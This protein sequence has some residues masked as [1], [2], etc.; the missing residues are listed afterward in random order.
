MGNVATVGVTQNTCGCHIG[1]YGSF[2]TQVLQPNI[3]ATS[4]T[5]YQTGTVITC[6]GTS[7]VQTKIANYSRACNATEHTH[8]DGTG[9]EHYCIADGMSLSVEGSLVRI[10]IVGRSTVVYQIPSD[11]DERSVGKVKV[12]TQ[13]TIDIS[14]TGIYHHGKDCPVAGC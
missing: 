10:S 14:C 3:T 4:T 9:L 5:A 8:T 11:R 13:H 12:G 6:D 1:R 7:A 2:V